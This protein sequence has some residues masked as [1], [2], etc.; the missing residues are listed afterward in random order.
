M[1]YIN[2]LF[3]EPLIKFLKD[4]FMLFYV[5]TIA[6]IG[7]AFGVWFIMKIYEW[8]LKTDT[9]IQILKVQLVDDK[10]SEVL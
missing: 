5:S 7:F 1:E 3:N 2:L 9:K 6:G 8:R 4:T 10:K